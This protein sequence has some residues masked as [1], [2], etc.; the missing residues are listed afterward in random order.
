MTRSSS[1]TVG[2]HRRI[3]W[4]R[5][6]WYWLAAYVLTL[7]TIVVL[8][9]GVRRATLRALSTPSAQAQWQAWRDSEPNR[10][11]TGGVKRRPPSSS[12]PPAL[13]LLRDY[14]GVMMTAAV[15]FG[16][17]LFGAIMVAAWGAFASSNAAI[18]SDTDPPPAR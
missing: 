18:H 6:K 13:V 12:E 10:T 7:G 16:S 15:V 1:D 4:Y 14:F 9:L 11:E 5:A 2:G 8:M 17:L 3:T